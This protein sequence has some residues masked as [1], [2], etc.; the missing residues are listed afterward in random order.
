MSK[1]PE[2]LPFLEAVSW[3]GEVDSQLTPEEMLHRYERGWH[4]RGVLAEPSAEELAFVQALSQRYGS[5]IVMSFSLEQH[6]KVRTILGKL[7]ADFLRHCEAYFGGGTYLALKYNEYRLS[8]DIDFLCSSTEGYRSIRQQIL[9][10]GYG[11]IFTDQSGIELPREIQANQ[12]G[13]RFPVLVEGTTIKFE[14]VS[15]GRIELDSPAT[16]DWLPVA[17]L[18]E[19]D[20]FAEKLLANADRWLDASVES[21]DL[22]DL[23]MLR[24][25]SPIPDAAIVKAEAAYPVVEPLR[26]AISNFQAKPDYRERCYQSLRIQSPPLVMN[27]IDLLASDFDQPATD[28]TSIEYDE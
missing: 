10:Q 11:A 6:Q 4:Y 28:R 3:Q 17:C 1:R 7:R 22:I 15:K 24:L 5:W 20:C 9:E 12:Y 27:G 21:R 2:T 8:K 13:I 19:M 16:P 18:S 14:I 26:R 25:Q 23:A